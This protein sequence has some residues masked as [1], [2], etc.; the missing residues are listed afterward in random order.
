VDALLKNDLKLWNTY[1]SLLEKID[2]LVKNNSL[3]KNYTLIYPSPELQIN[4]LKPK[5]KIL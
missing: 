2:Q 4:W 5:N 1:I 3:Y